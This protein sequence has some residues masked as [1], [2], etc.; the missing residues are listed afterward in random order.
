[1]PMPCC[2]GS[3][4][5]LTFSLMCLPLAPVM[6]RSSALGP[7]IGLMPPSGLLNGVSLPLQMAS[8]TLLGVLPITM[9]TAR[10]AKWSVP[11]GI[12]VRSLQ[13]SYL[14]PPSP[15]ASLRGACSTAFTMA[16]RSPPGTVFL[17]WCSAVP[18]SSAGG[19]YLIPPGNMSF[20]FVATSLPSAICAGTRTTAGLRPTRT[21]W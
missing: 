16:S 20:S 9:S 18:G 4:V 7:D 8:T 3:H 15:G 12:F 6:S 5:P 19:W 21:P 14:D 13:C 2:M 1:M 10:L 11:P 17:A